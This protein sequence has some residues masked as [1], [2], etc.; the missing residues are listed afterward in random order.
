MN[1]M[2]L[3]VSLDLAHLRNEAHVELNETIDRLIGNYTPE[4]LG[5]V[6]QYREYQPLFA[7]EVSVLDLIRELAAGE[8]PAL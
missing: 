8:S 7:D 6:P 3:I 4:A 2:N 5:I 1:M